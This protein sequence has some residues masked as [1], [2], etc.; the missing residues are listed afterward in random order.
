MGDLMREATELIGGRG[1]GRPN[2]A[3]GGGPNADA[4]AQALDYIVVKITS[5]KLSAPPPQ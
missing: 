3:M 4:I 1:G 2:M 5:E